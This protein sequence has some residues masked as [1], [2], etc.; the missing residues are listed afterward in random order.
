[1]DKKHFNIRFRSLVIQT[2]NK[3]LMAKKPT[4]HLLRHSIATHMINRGADVN[5]VRRFLGHTSLNTTVGIYAKRR[6]QK[7]KLYELYRRQS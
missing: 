4:L 1:M 3:E 2:G 6:K 7:A 5:Y